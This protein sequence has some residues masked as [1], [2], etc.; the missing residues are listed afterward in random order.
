MHETIAAVILAGGQGRRL[1]NVDKAM[2]RLAGRPL[3]AHVLERLHGQVP[4]ILL[5]ANG[6]PARLSNFGLPVAADAG[7]DLGPL[8]GIAAGAQ[9]CKDRWP[10]L[11]H[12]L[13][14][15]VDTPLLPLDL[16]DRLVEGVATAPGC[17]MVAAAGGR[18]HWTIALWP[19]ES[20]AA[21]ADRVLQDGMRRLQEG[22]EIVGWRHVPFPDAN[23]F[24]NINN[25]QDYDSVTQSLIEN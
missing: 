1:G 13:T 2:L 4:R 18:M 23:A 11:T 15:P 24:T 20:A 22:L 16:A 3:L 21:L 19:I 14:V 6:D 10:G 12:I 8:A 5:S 25:L 9:G 7:P 17:A